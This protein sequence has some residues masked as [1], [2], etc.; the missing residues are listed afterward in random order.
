[1]SSTPDLL[2]SALNAA[3]V[4]PVQDP[5]N[6]ADSLK[7]GLGGYGIR[8]K[9]HVETETAVREY[10]SDLRQYVEHAAA[11]LDLPGDPAGLYDPVRYVLGMGGKRLR[12]VMVVLAAEMVA[13]GNREAR[14]A[15]LNPAL[16]VE[17]FH[18]FSLLHDD[19]MDEAPLR[20][21]KPTV[22]IKWNPNTAIL[23]GDLMLVEAFRLASTGPADV[24]ADIL[25]TFSQTAREVCEGQQ[26][27]MDFEQRMDVTV[28]EY[29]S[30][31][32]RKTAVLLAASLSIG[33]RCG[34]ASAEIAELLYEYGISIGLAF[35]LRDDYLDAWG[36]PERFG[37]TVGGDIIQNKKTFLLIRAL[38]KAQGAERDELDRWIA[39][40]DFEPAEKVAAVLELFAK[41]GIREEVE[42]AEK[43]H[44]ERAAGLLAQ[45]Q[46]S[47]IETQMLEAFVD[48][49]LARQ[50]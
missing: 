48:D 20:R 21:G 40:T 47:G 15:A 36:D 4:S 50:H 3:A 1:L 44:A 27:D 30:M 37:K 45:L 41:L 7:P 9:Q 12:P 11:N 34:G 31:I 14:K 24:S 22:H 16:G 8:T 28:E 35:Q 26:L 17:V 6:L 46:E 38:E 25:K 43:E 42:A 18:N 10:L 33:A 32:R 23:S 49:L 29:T 2:S 5:Q 13:P 39:A 19:I